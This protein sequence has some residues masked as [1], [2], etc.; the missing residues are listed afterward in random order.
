ML[1]ARVIGNVVTTKKDTGLQDRT[2]LLIQP[3]AHTG[4]ATGRPLV[5]FDS[6]GAGA[7]ENVFYVRGSEASFPF[8]PSVVP[9]DATIIGIIDH[10]S[11]ETPAPARTPPR[12]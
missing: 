10:W 12:R 6:V 7:G 3:L 2:L 11:V 5:A 9:A 1:I 8:L 4:E